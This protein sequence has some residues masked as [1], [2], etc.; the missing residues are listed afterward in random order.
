MAQDFFDQHKVARTIFE[1]ASDATGEDI[2]KLCFEEDP[3]LDLTEF[4]QPCILTA[5]IAML[6]VLRADYFRTR[7]GRYGR[8]YRQ[9]VF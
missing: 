6:E 8:R 4:T 1:R 9:T 3:R 5:E 7:V 2:A